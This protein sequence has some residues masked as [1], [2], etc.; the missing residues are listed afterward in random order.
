MN[1]EKR[2]GSLLLKLGI[3]PEPAAVSLNATNEA[4]LKRIPDKAHAMTRACYSRNPE[5]SQT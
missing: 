1:R 4:L 2:T 5:S 3:K